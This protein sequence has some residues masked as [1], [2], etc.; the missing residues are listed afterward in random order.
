MAKD[1]ES[2]LV[3]LAEALTGVLNSPPEGAFSQALR[4]HR[5]YNPEYDLKER[6]ELVTSVVPRKRDW[7]RESRVEVA[8]ELQ[9]DVAVQR[10]LKDCTP[11]EIDPLIA[12]VEEIVAYFRKNP[13]VGPAVFVS[14][15]ANPVYSQEHLQ[16]FRQFT[17][18]TTLTFKMRYA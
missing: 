11:S 15:D 16:Q 17:A 4:A 12:L 18:V 9:I 5:T 8:E 2:T 6:K 3:Q 1:M 13:A 14:A 10:K 7:T